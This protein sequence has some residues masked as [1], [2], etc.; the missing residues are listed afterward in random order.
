MPMYVGLTDDPVRRL[1]E[2]GSPKGWQ[3]FGQGWSRIAGASG[4][5]VALEAQ[6]DTGV[7][8][9][10]RGGADAATSPRRRVGLGVL[11]GGVLLP[12]ADDQR[13]D[14][15]HQGNRRP[16]PARSTF[17]DHGIPEGRRSK[18]STP[19]PHPSLEFGP[20]PRR[21]AVERSL[22]AARSLSTSRR[23]RRRSQTRRAKA[24][25]SL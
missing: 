19:G 18:V 2:H 12:A 4:R 11:G 25:G 6:R 10:L 22:D 1:A 3:I 15:D 16:R 7:A 14:R 20:L 17:P 13:S 21:G 23:F 9:R 5:S 8:A 24:A